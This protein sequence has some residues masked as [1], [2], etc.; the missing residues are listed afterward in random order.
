MPGARDEPEAFA[1]FIERLQNHRMDVGTSRRRGRMHQVAETCVHRDLFHPLQTAVPVAEPA[2][3]Q[4]SWRDR[5]A[6]TRSPSRFQLY[7]PFDFRTGFLGAL[8]AIEDATHM[9]HV[10]GAQMFFRSDE[11]LLFLFANVMEVFFLGRRKTT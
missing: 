5:R 2:M 11:L 6:S 8:S 4:V 9:P 7:L 10:G 1:K 3:R